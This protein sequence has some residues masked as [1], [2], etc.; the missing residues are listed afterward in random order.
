MSNKIE[1]GCEEGMNDPSWIGNVEP[2]A[3]KVLARLDIDGWELSVLL[4][5]ITSYNACYT[6]LLRKCRRR[7]SRHW[8]RNDTAPDLTCDG[9]VLLRCY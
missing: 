5:R 8:H 1:V 4:C 3:Q 6:K 7:E 2:F 9:A